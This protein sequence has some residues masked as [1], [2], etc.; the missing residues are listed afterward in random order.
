MT[1]PDP[2]VGGAGMIPTAHPGTYGLWHAIYAIVAVHARYNRDALLAAV[3]EQRDKHPRPKE[4][5]NA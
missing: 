2:E 5:S 4:S 1:T 3:A